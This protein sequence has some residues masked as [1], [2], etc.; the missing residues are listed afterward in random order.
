MDKK[1]YILKFGGTSVGKLDGINNIKTILNKENEN[2][3]IKLV[4]VSAACDST[5]M[6][7]NLYLT[8]VNNEKEN[9]DN[10]LENYKL[11]ENNL[12]KSLEIDEYNDYFTDLKNTFDNYRNQE[13][14]QDKLKD[15]ILSF[16]ELISMNR[17]YDFLLKENNNQ[18]TKILKIPSWDLGF[19]RFEYL[20]FSFSDTL[21]QNKLENV[22]QEN[23]SFNNI[24]II[25][26]G[27]IAK[28]KNQEIITLGRGGSDLSATLFAKALNPIHVQIWS[29]V[30]GIMTS[31]PK[32][33]KNT[34]LIN[35]LTYNEALELSF[36]GA[37]ILHPETIKPILKQEIPV[38]I[39]N[40]FDL[41][42]KGTIITKF[43][44]SEKRTSIVKCISYNDENT[45]IYIEPKNTYITNNFICD[46]FLMLNNMDI[47]C[48]MISFSKT[49]LSICIKTE[50]KSE[51]L[52]QTLTFN[53]TNNIVYTDKIGVVCVVGESLYELQGIASKIFSTVS[54]CKTNIEMISQ[55]VS[56]TNI[57][58]AIKQDNI[59][60]VVQKI[61]DKFC[62]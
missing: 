25:T 4:V 32:Y 19:I 9:F 2:N 44:K 46:V 30:P 58:F 56:Q 61:H 60:N 23:S 53:N 59:S 7:E 39:L 24:H 35:N 21:I 20:N 31:N 36:F 13:I 17:L 41:N 15:Y 45:I 47:K 62:L 22:I 16:G 1:L 28:N 29:D 10:L 18:S 57:L 43:N 3:I 33:I 54:D 12:N 49:S 34:K 6:L 14:K 8:I 37:K 51:K 26:T 5:N 48:S 55:S 42:S 38:Y 50:Y 27:F 40:T 11:H 52:L